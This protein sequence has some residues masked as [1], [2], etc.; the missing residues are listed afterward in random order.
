ML[1]SRP[2]G[3]KAKAPKPKVISL[4][5]GSSGNAFYIAYK[6]TAVLVDA[7]FSA[8]ETAR[9]LRAR[10]IDPETLDALLIT[11]E[12]VDHVRGIAVLS[13]RFKIPVY[14]SPY[15]YGAYKRKGKAVPEREEFLPG[16]AFTIGNLEILPFP[17]PHDAADP[18]G[19]RIQAGPWLIGLATDLG[20]PSDE[21]IDHLRDGDILVLESNHDVDMLKKGPYPWMLKKRILGKSGHL[22]NEALGGMLEE[23]VTERCRVVVP[24]HISKINN[25][26]EVA[27]LSCEIALIRLG[28]DSVR[29]V[30]AE[31]D[32]PV[33]I[34][35][36]A[37]DDV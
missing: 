14:A 4:G 34:W 21:V 1:K 29:V 3:K 11:H 8:R 9:R 25:E 35:G 24:A 32:W 2:S 20:H 19:F 15:T 10:D 23:V 12:H 36:L 16:H 5:S 30:P 7:G 22:S 13:K 27:R 31:Q 26:K 6:G 33:D 28:L 18:V 17:V 37:A